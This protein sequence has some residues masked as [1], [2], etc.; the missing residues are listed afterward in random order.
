M[1]KSLEERFAKVDDVVLFHLQTVWEAENVNTPARGHQEVKTHGVKVPVAYDGH[2]DGAYTSVF[3][4]RYGT[5]GTPWTVVID[6]KGKVRISQFTP[7]T[8][9]QLM[10]RIE[11]LRKER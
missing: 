3:M 10:E 6:K 1:H 7:G 9:E 2:V 4:H 5:G 8:P 11:K